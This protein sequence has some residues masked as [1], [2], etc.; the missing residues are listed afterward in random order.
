MTKRE[1]ETGYFVDV[2][3]GERLEDGEC[4]AD[5]V[6]LVG[7]DEMGLW[8]G[9]QDAAWVLSHRSGPT[10]E[11]W[12]EIGGEPWQ[13]VFVGTLEEAVAYAENHGVRVKGAF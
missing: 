9:T 4:D 8:W 5:G 6:D 12:G 13:G 11:V 3:T 1:T 7:C 2:C 10:V